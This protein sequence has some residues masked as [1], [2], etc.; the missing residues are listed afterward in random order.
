ML[1]SL[2]LFTGTGGIAYALRGGIAKPAAYCE[3]SPDARAILAGNMDRGFVHRAPV[4]EDV[5]KLDPADYRGVDLIAGGFPCVGLSSMGHRKGLLH[6]AS[7]LF[8]RVVELAEAIRPPL[9]FLENV[10]NIVSLALDEV[11]LQLG[12]RL[13]YELRWVSSPAYVVGAPQ[14]RERWFLLAVRPGFERAIKLQRVA[15]FDWSAKPPR[16]MV[17]HKDPNY[18]ARMG[19]LGN[20]VVPDA[21]MSSPEPT[22]DEALRL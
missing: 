18:L 4:E 6:P 17:P 11:I 13:G 3:V 22:V 14:F 15:A 20:G 8:Y 9:M 16:R 7:A 1:R 2:D 10:P 12:G 21:V 5:V 19:A